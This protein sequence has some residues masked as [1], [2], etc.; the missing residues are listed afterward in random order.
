MQNNCLRENNRKR[1]QCQTN[2]CSKLILVKGHKG[3]TG[4]TGSTGA[5]GATGQNGLTG[6]TGSIGPTGITGQTGTTGPIGAIGSIGNT[7][8]TGTTGDTGDIGMTGSTGPTGSIG[9]TG[10]TGETGITGSIGSLGATGPTGLPL[11]IAS[12]CTAITMVSTGGTG[13]WTIISSPNIVSYINVGAVVI[14]TLNG[15]FTASVAGSTALSHQFHVV[16][17]SGLPVPP[18]GTSCVGAVGAAGMIG[19]TGPNVFVSKAAFAGSQ[20]VISF[21]GNSLP[22]ASDTIYS[23]T[24]QVVYAL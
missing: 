20:I 12:G 8:A 2:D 11:Q 21:L 5:T 19:T 15:Q 7:G 18:D 24:F 3:A 10:P 17:T 1:C 23:G 9:N 22:I 4:Q 13:D 16:I 6:T 14:A